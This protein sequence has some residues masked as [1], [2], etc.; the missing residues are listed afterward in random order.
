MKQLLNEDIVKKY[1][2]IQLADQG[3]TFMS[4]S[5]AL[6]K[7]KEAG[8]DLVLVSV[9][10][11]NMAI[12]KIMDHKKY[13]Y[14]KKKAKK[15][16]TKTVLKE[17]K[18]GKLD[19]GQHDLERFAKQASKFIEKF[20]QVKMTVGFKGGRGL[21][22]AHEGPSVLKR[23]LE[24]SQKHALSHYYG[25]T[26]SPKKGGRQW[27]VIIKKTKQKIEKNEGA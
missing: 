26:T 20:G 23:A 3:L 15:A 13:L 16:T 25:F 12:C 10:K 22:R 7:A 6:N 4:S 27:S 8:M 18:L 21:A 19:V 2:S 5:K 24:E 9:N 17:V 14:D 11:S 1:K